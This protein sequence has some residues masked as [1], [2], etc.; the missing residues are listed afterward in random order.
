M[1][2][3]TQALLMEFWCQGDEERSLG[4]SISPLCD[5]ESE[6]LEVPKGQ[7]G[8]INFVIEP[9]YRTIVLLIPES[10]EAVDNLT[11]NKEFWQQKKLEMATF[12]TIF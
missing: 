6:M 12:N 3:W 7:L 8:F 1:L 5:R 9:L 2:Q 4:Q 10:Q 11:K